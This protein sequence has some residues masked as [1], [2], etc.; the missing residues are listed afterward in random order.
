MRKFVNDQY[1]LLNLQ[2]YNN[3]KP[4]LYHCEILYHYIASKAYVSLQTSMETVII[5]WYT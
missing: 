5:H 1:D 4:V 3:Q 2:L